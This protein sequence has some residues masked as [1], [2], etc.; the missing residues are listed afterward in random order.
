MIKYNKLYL[1]VKYILN[2]NRT[3]LVLKY[4]WEHS[5]EEHQVTAKDILSYLEEN[6][7]STISRRIKADVELLRDFGFDIEVVHSTQ[8]RYYMY[9]RNFELA[10]LK[11]LI[12]AVQ[13]AK[14][15]TNKKSK[16]LIEKLSVFASEHQQSELKRQLYIDKRV[17]TDNEGGYYS[18][19]SIHTA[20]QRKK[21][22]TFKYLEFAPDKT[23]RE[24][25]NGQVYVLSPYALIWNDD[26]YYV[27]GYSEAANHNK[28]VKF[29][30]DRMKNLSVTDNPAIRKPKD[31]NVEDY[32]K[33]IFSMYDGEECEVELLCDNELMKHIVDRFG[34]KVQTKQSDNK[35]FSATV[36]VSLSPTFYG[37]VF[38][39]GGEMKL[40]SPTRAVNGFENMLNRF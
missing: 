7:I 39:F 18:V 16:K 9:E 36:T 3:L 27:I 17:K 24:K 21:K 5:D 6:R 26:S 1:G 37:W 19:D 30:I 15:I 34:E 38:S 4:I 35:H 32:F 31:F 14:F 2:Q 23:K 8:N 20:I 22:I 33:Q 12:D 28:I 29:R 25:H 11:L 13:S 40:I 10:E